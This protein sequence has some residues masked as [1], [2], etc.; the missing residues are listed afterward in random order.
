MKYNDD[1]DCHDRC[2]DS[3]HYKEIED[4]DA[5]ASVPYVLNH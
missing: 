5:A 3:M 2:V 4:T 1:A